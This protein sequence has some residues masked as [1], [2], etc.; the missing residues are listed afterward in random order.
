MPRRNR[1]TP[2]GDLIAVPDRG[3]VYGNRGCLHDAAGD[4][5]RRFQVKRWIACRLEFNG[6]HRSP[7]LQPGFESSVPKLHFVGSYAVKSFGP[8][9]R[10]IAGA[11]FAARSVAAAANA[12]ATRHVGAESA[13]AATSSFSRAP[14]VSP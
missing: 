10:F 8:L 5:R 14:R 12:R 11:P 6:W 1:V 4:I 9:M 13:K 7:L 3:L 2:L